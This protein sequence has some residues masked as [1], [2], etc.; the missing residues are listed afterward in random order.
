MVGSVLDVGDWLAAISQFA[1]AA[2]GAFVSIGVWYASKSRENARRHAETLEMVRR[3]RETTSGS[4]KALQ[5]N[6]Q[7]AVQSIE[8]FVSRLEEQ[9][10]VDLEQDKVDRARFLAA[11]EVPWPRLLEKFPATT[12]VFEPNELIA[13]SSI[14]NEHARFS[15]Q[16]DIFTT[17]GI[18][19]TRDSLNTVKERA[20]R[21]LGYIK[22]S[23]LT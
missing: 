12:D 6:L 10:V 19:L 3:T 14:E 11:A 4:L 13:I 7:Y 21:I 9:R 20:V 8:E 5:S 22:D 1:G 18:A 23:N 16:I 15:S 17:S 2:V